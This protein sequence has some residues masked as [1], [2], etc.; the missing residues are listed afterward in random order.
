MQ[1]HPLRRISAPR[2]IAGPFGA[3]G[4]ERQLPLFKYGPLGEDCGETVGSHIIKSLYVGFPLY[5]D[6]DFGEI[7]SI[8]NKKKT[9]TDKEL[10]MRINNRRD[11]SDCNNRKGIILE[12]RNV[13][14]GVARPD[15]AQCVREYIEDMAGELSQMARS[16]GDSFLGYLLHMAAQEAELLRTGERSNAA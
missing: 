4:L 14:H 10:L 5:R 1:S 6:K 9:K 2:W 13:S 12:L 3:D 11:T 8:K 16:S 7:M 15:H